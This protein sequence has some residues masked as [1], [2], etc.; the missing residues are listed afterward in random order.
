MEINDRVLLDAS[1]YVLFEATGDSEAQ[2]F[3]GDLESQHSDAAEDDALSCSYA[4]SGKEVDG[5]DD[6]DD[7][8][9]PA[10]FDL[11]NWIVG[12]EDDDGGGGGG[13]MSDLE[14]GVVDQ[15][16]G[17]GKAAAAKE[18][19]K[20]SKGCCEDLKMISEREG[21]RLFWEACLASQE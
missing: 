8:R 3:G 19:V 2:H 5:G 6:D 9:P 1:A 14:D 11:D 12:G 21:D 18:K 16:R 7:F 17:G 20:K 10:D 4:R 15:C 13:G